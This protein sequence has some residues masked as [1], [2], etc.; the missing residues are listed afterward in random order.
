MLV[1]GFSCFGV[2][3]VG[4]DAIWP[5]DVP[6]GLD[7][8]RSKD[9]MRAAE[10]V[11]ISQRA[12]VGFQMC[13]AGGGHEDLDAVEALCRLPFSITR[14]LVWHGYDDLGNG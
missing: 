4:T 8:I 9:G 3:V 2:A 13:D 10:E 12:R 5:P 14:L 6:S 7:S 11:R 1:S